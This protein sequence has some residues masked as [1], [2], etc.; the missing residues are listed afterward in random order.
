MGR[1]ASKITAVVFEQESACSRFGAYAFSGCTS[2]AVIDVPLGVTD[3]G[4]LAFDRC[5]SLAYSEYDNAYYLG[6]QQNPYMVLVRAKDPSVVS[7]RMHADTRVIAGAAFLSC[8]DLKSVVFSANVITVG[9]S[10]FE[11]CS[12][13]E[14]VTV[15]ESVRRIGER[16]FADC[17]SL[18]GVSLA[19]G[20]HTVGDRAFEGC[21][22]LTRL[23]IPQS[24]QVLGTW[25]FYRC[26]A[27]TVYC[28]TATMP[29]G[30]A[31]TWNPDGQPVRW[32]YA[33]N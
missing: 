27:L 23:V 9:D 25:V 30:W 14:R 1:A 29:G 19:E 12:V 22:A 2:L 13:L 31:A 32:G 17:I 33:G 28:R 24:V 4:V 11:R 20:T 16:A 15:P 21:T 7:C 5:T 6:N 10:A 18:L 3:I 26:A 8:A